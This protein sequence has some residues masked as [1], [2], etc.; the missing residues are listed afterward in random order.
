[1]IDINNV[2]AGWANLRIGYCTFYVSYLSD[3]KAELD[4]LFFGLDNK[5]ENMVHRIVL[6]GENNGDLSLV[7]YLTYEELNPYLTMEEQKDRGDIDYCD[8][9]LNIVWQNIYSQRTSSIAILKFPYKKFLEEYKKLTKEIKEKYIE[10]FL[11]SIS[12][13]EY[14][15]ALLEYDNREEDEYV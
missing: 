3:L 11:C 8:S 12:K 10:E 6:S 15:R 1:M 14:Q 13:T 2:F 7:A 4:D 9:V 5:T